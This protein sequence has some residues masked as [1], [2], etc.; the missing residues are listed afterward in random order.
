VLVL[1][2]AQLLPVSAQVL[3]G[4]IEIQGVHAGPFNPTAWQQD[5][6]NWVPECEAPSAFPNPGMGWSV[7]ASGV[8]CN[9]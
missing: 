5:T 8:A 1:V 6:L 4:T 3:P 2:A 9:W 7:V